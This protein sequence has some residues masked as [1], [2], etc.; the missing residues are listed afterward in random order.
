MVVRCMMFDLEGL[1]KKQ[2]SVKRIKNGTHKECAITE[3][4]KGYV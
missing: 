1:N 3:L 2:M 4:N